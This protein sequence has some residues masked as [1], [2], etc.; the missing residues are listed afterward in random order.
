MKYRWSAWLVMVGWMGVA[1]A[2][3]AVDLSLGAPVPDVRARVLDSDSVFSLAQSRGKVVIIN[4]WATWCG[5]CKAEM[6]LLQAYY[7][8]HRAQGLEV[9]AISMDDA[10]AL[11]EVRQSARQFGLP[12]ALKKEADFKGLGRIWRLPTTFVV[13]RQGLLRRDGQHGDAEITAAEL[14][15]LVTPL[16]QEH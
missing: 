11:P 6:P 14:D 4:F 3:G 16:L 2:A 7:A 15:T 8:A 1:S 12:V 9:L 10:R 5:P 13:D